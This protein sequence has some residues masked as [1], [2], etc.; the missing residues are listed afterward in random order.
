MID[1]FDRWFSREIPAQ[2]DAKMT[3]SK[4]GLFVTTIGMALGVTGLAFAGGGNVHPSNAKS[5]GYSLI[6]MAK[7]TA[8]YNS[9]SAAF[10]PSPSNPPPKVP[11]Q[12][13]VA[14][15]TVSP[16]TWI[17]VPVFYTDDAGGAPP[18][19]P[20]NV[21]DQA[22]DAAFLE[23][24]IFDFGGFGITSLF[25]EVDSQITTLDGGYIS[26]VISPK[27]LVDGTPSGSRYIC[28]A[29]FLTPLSPGVH[30]VN[31]G[32]IIEGEPVAFLTYKVTV[33]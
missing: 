12:V 1:R 24:Y 23:S 6:D 11:F 4:R 31:I 18:G 27:P 10:G 20:A 29:A 7:I 21:G 15:A 8:Y 9:Y 28:S 5:Q 22:A 2:E 19:F 26:G 17:Y 3:M 25:L 30:T 14:D 13:L 33:R 32:G 16:G